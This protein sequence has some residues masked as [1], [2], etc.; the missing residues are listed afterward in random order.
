ML[1]YSK[2]DSWLTAYIF[3]ERSRHITDISY[4][5]CNGAEHI[6][7]L[8]RYNVFSTRILIRHAASRNMYLYDVLKIKKET[9]KSC[10]E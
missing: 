7:S 1:F 2:R 8:E 4:R 3:S 6:R 10:Q 9:S 5:T